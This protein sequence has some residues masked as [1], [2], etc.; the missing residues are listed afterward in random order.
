MPLPTKGSPSSSRGDFSQA[1]S[2][3]ET[4]ASKS[5]SEHRPQAIPAPQ[6]KGMGES[7]VNRDAHYKKQAETA[8]ATKPKNSN[9]NNV[10][11]EKRAAKAFEMVAS[12]DGV[13]R[14]NNSKER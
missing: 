7:S 14:S 13:I 9:R 10:V 5:P 8:R 6:P 12:K 11:K 1:A 3:V 4:S 2:G